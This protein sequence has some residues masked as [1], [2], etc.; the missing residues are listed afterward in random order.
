[1]QILV[2]RTHV[3]D[4][5]TPAKLN[6]KEAETH[7]PDLPETQDVVCCI[8]ILHSPLSVPSDAQRR[9]CFVLI[10]CCR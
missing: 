1:M 6:A 9:W 5:Q 2:D 7:V 3:G 4:L 10:S 8:V